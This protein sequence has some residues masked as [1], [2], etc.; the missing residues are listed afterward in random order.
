MK[1]IFLFSFIVLFTNCSTLE[2]ILGQISSNL[3]GEQFSDAPKSTT[4]PSSTRTTIT[5]PNRNYNIPASYEKAYSFRTDTPDQR[6]IRIPQNIE[7]N[8]AN[9]PNEY[10]KQIAAYIND[11]STDDFDRVKK[12][13]DLVAVIISYDAAN[14]WANTVPDQSYQNVL[15][16][17]LAVCEGYANLFKRLCDELNIICDKV[18]GYA[19]G[20]GSSPLANDTPNNSNHA[21]NIVTINSESYLVDCTW[22]SG[23]M[24]GRTAKQQYT[25]DWLFM[26]P[27]QFLYT[28]YPEN[29]RQQLLLNPMTAAQFSSLPFLR[30]KFFDLVDNLS[31]DLKKINKVENKLSFE[32]KTKE[33]YSLSFSVNEINSGR[34]IQNST[35]V[36]NDGTKEIAYFSFPTVG[37]YSVN[38][39]WWKTGTRQGE[40]CGEFVVETSSTSLLQYP[41]TYSSSAKNLQLLSPLE[42]PLERGKTYTFRIKVDNKN[43]V[44]IIH[45]RTFV[46]LTKD[47]DGIFTAEFE[48]PA[49]IN[50]LSIGIADSERGQYENILQYQVK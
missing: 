31:I 5:T 33:G 4:T 27:E 6:M 3:E 46:Q 25:T 19:R 11:N 39:F 32:Y 42:M 37:Q 48:I 13:H 44:A 29:S 18:T 40:G 14:F 43:I 35:F 8:R 38:I 36:Q 34:Q 45:G 30:P 50:N 23:Y 9:N 1:K 47:S 15:R 7:T 12:A 24:D 21:W 17:R 10:I 16:T 41:T 28:H 22:D 26:K 20:V 2:G 49:N